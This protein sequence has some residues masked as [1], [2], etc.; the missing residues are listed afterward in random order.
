M[1]ILFAADYHL[2]T[3]PKLRQGVT[4]QKICRCSKVRAPICPSRPLFD[5][6]GYAEGR[7]YVVILQY[8]YCV[9]HGSGAEG[10]QRRV[11]NICTVQPGNMQVVHHARL[12]TIS[13]QSIGLPGGNHADQNSKKPKKSSKTS[14]N[15]IQTSANIRMS[16]SF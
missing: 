16:A 14:P 1:M 4:F 6:R 11:C 12:P 2:T 3:K 15:L 8:V 13:F 10:M 7:R 9:Y 5:R